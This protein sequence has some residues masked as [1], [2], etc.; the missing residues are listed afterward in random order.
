LNNT[1]GKR[2]HVVFVRNGK[3]GSLFINGVLSASGTSSLADPVI[4]NNYDLVIGGDYRDRV[5]YFSGSIDNVNIYFY[6][7]T[8]EQISQLYF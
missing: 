2:T 4:Y 5:Q 3:Q 1:K 6:F 7:L 8:Q